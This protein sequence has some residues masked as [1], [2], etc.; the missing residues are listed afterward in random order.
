MTEIENSC[1][2]CGNAT[3]GEVAFTMKLGAIFTA[4]GF[5]GGCGAMNTA[6]AGS[7]D[8]TIF[9]VRPY[10]NCPAWEAKEK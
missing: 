1:L 3:W 4:S 7:V 10:I 8:A 2:D 5:A 9:S 6:P